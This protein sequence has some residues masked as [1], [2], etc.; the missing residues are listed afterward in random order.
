MTY[1]YEE[2]DFYYGYS[3][4]DLQVQ[5]FKDQLKKSV[6]QELLDEMNKLKKRK[7]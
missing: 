4:F 3:E 1:Y 2:D 6:K 5:E 7:R